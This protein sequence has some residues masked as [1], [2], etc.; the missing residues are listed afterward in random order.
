VSEPSQDLIDVPVRPAGPFA[1]YIAPALLI[2]LSVAVG[3]FSPGSHVPDNL[4]GAP[5]QRLQSLLGLCSFIFLAYLLG[6]IRNRR[7]SPFPWRALLWGVALQF[8]F[9]ALVLKVP[10]LLE[11]VNQFI[12]ALLGFTRK[13]AEI[14]FGNLIN[15]DVPVTVTAPDG[16]SLVGTAE[17]GAYFAFFVLPTILF[18]STLTAIAWHTGVMQ[19]VVQGLAWIM[20]KSMRTSG[21]ETLTVAANIFVG[22]A[23]SPLII[24]PFL[25]TVTNS[26][27]MCIMVAGF[28][29]IASGVLGLY[30][31]WLGPYIANVGGHLAAACFISAP[32]SLL[33]S[34]LLLPET[35][36]PQTAA[37]VTF[38]V[39]RTG[40]NIIDAATRGT[41]DGLGLALNV[42]AMLVTFTAI[43]ALLNFLLTWVCAKTHISHGQPLTLQQMLGYPMSPLAWLSGVSW[44]DSRAVGSLL[45]IK[46]VLNELLA[47]KDMKQSFAQN[48]LF[49][50][51]R[52][53]LI[54]AYSLCGF[55]NF[56]SIGIQVGGIST[57]APSRR[58]DLSRL[59]LLAM[60]GGAIASFTTA[61]VIG[62][63]L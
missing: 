18:F 12:N 5:A 57:L 37:G 15:N 1:S 28:A 47:Y 20:S 10:D 53:A 35:T 60:I 40:T 59:G 21:A 49:I 36:V 52:S 34:K 41:S 24:K 50:S 44:H 56:A 38:K 58:T 11:A 27:L 22:Q 43:V 8:A 63:L 4:R 9:G 6:R 48:P 45:G 42:A 51:P 54:A 62:I 19:Y 3:W 13:G 7:A 61:S 26:E 25:N 39:E 23:E 30:T 32:A 29:N 17:T 16:H 2:L 55:A 14:V 46:T 33:I 31:F